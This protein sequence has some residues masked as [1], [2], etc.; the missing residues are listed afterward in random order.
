MSINYKQGVLN[1]LMN[2]FGKLIG[3]TILDNYLEDAGLKSLN[4]LQEHEQVKFIDNILESILNKHYSREEIENIKIQLSIQVCIDQAAD[5]TTQ[6]LGEKISIDPIKV[7]HRS[8]KEFLAT[9]EHLLND[10]EP[11]YVKIEGDNEGRAV[12]FIPKDQ[13][14]KINDA[15]LDKLMEGQRDLSHHAIKQ[16]FM[17]FCTPLSEAFKE[18]LEKNITL[19]VTLGNPEKMFKEL[20]EPTIVSSDITLHIK[21]ESYKGI[22]YI[23]ISK[24]N[25]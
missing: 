23:L 14:E 5:A 25:I 13:V 6:V 16:L 24:K 3:E 4:D 12:F 19:T 15:V 18:V 22:I 8:D 10:N 21:T 11:I 7:S 9:A 1:F 17:M 2:R 20:Q